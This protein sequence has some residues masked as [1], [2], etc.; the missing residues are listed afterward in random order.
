MGVCM[1][2]LLFLAANL[3]LVGLAKHL[4]HRPPPAVQSETWVLSWSRFN[5]G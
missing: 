5:F 2:H 3:I 4:S 1:S